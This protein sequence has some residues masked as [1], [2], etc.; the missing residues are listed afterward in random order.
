[1]PYGSSTYGTSTY[2]APTYNQAVDALPA[3]LYHWKL[4]ETSGSAVDRKGNYPVALTV[5]GG[6]TQGVTGLVTNNSSDLAASFNGGGT[7]DIYGASSNP[8]V[9]YPTFAFAAEIT[10]DATNTLPAS[11]DQYIAGF[12]NASTSTYA[13]IFLRGNK[14]GVYFRYSGGYREALGATSLAAAGTY[15]ITG[16]YDGSTLTVRVNGV[17]DGTLSTTDTPT[18]GAQ[19]IV[20]GNNWALNSGFKGVID[21]VAFYTQPLPAANDL[22]IYNAGH[23]SNDRTGTASATGSGTA[24]ATG[25]KGVSSS[26]SGSAAA[27]ASATAAKGTTASASATATGTAS[28]TGG[29]TVSHTADA[30]AIATASVAGYKGALAAASVSGSGTAAAQATAVK[31]AAGSASATAAAVAQVTGGQGVAA[32]ASA[33]ASGAASAT[34]R[35]DA[36]GAASASAVGSVSATGHQA[37]SRDGVRTRN[38]RALIFSRETTVAI[39]PHET[40]AAIT[41]R[42]TETSIQPRETEGGID[43]V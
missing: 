22:A 9:N 23:V 25:V 2:E 15:R 20:I 14:A 37:G 43:D 16:T 7:S 19:A 21:E 38:N 30:S 36:K 5:E 10:I 33:T 26:A 18:G 28:A 4:G 31:G 11:P 41:A 34:G 42:E 3:P 17:S 12:H 29:I 27:A 39:T 8:T 32:S 6:V 24:G 40:S 1:M 35:K 13:G